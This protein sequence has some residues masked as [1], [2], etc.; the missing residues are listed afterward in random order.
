[1]A[2]IGPNMGGIVITFLK[3]I[4]Y[5]L[6]LITIGSGNNRIQMLSAS[7]C[8]DAI[9]KAEKYNKTG[10]VFN[11]GS[12]NVPTFRHQLKEVVKNANST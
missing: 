10:E 4:R 1:M 11:L 7:D 8:V 2:M 12:E 6:P 3:F 9:L 5:N